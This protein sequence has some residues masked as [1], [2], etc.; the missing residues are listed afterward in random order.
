MYFLVGHFDLTS[1]NGNSRFRKRMKHIE[2]SSLI[3]NFEGKLPE[4]SAAVIREHLA[5]CADCM[6]DSA[7]VAQ[8]FAYAG[9]QCFEPVPQAATANILNVYQRRIEQAVARSPARSFL[10]FDD[11]TM[12]VN[13]RFSGSESRQLLF[14]VGDFTI[15]LRLDFQG[16]NCSVSGQIFPDA[17]NA[18]IYMVSAE[19]SLTGSFGEFGE[20]SFDPAPQD[21]Y[22]IRLSIA[23]TDFSIPRVSMQR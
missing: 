3:E 15:D 13:E 19:R 14:E 11:W 22:E 16:E 9:S 7:K 17:E 20:F 18:A 2:F 1:R 23:S 5:A 8:F 10:V 4:S 12:A 6:S 21:I